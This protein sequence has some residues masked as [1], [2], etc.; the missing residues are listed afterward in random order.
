MDIENIF[1]QFNHISTFQDAEA[2]DSGHINNTYL[3]LTQDSAAPDYVLQKINSAVFKNIPALIQNKVLVTDFLRAKASDEDKENIVRLIPTLSGEHYYID[4]NNDYWNLM[5]FIPD[6]GVYLM[7]ISTKI[8][9]E[10]GRLFGQFFY[11]LNDFEANKLSETIPRFH[12]MDHRLAQLKIPSNS[13]VT[14]ILKI[15]V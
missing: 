6:S 10:A 14:G 7:T 3:V 15:I 12:D 2:I 13:S 5:V 9:A 4:S 1:N 8:A 11:L